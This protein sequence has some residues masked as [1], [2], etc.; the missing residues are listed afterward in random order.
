MN[1]ILTVKLDA[2]VL[3]GEHTSQEIESSVKSAI[4]NAI[5]QAEENGFNH[6]LSEDIAISLED[7]R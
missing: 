6:R 5:L 7:I 1:V 2:E 4:R 3:D